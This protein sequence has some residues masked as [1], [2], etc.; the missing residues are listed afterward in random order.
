MAGIGV[1][2]NRMFGR[3]SVFSEVYG[4]V[5]SSATTIAPMILI[6]GSLLLVYQ[7]F[8]F[9]TISYA[10]RALF[11]CSLLYVFV[12]S[13][14]V[15]SIYNTLFSKYLADKTYEEKFGDILPCFYTGLF[16]C[17]ITGAVFAIP[18]YVYEF[19]VGGVDIIYVFT[20]YCLFIALTLTY[21]AMIFMSF[22]KEYKKISLY[23]L[24]GMLLMFFLCWLFISVL[25]I[26]KTFS[27]VLALTLG[28]LLIATLEIL[29]IRRC[30]SENSRNYSGI[31]K[32]M[33][34]HWKLMAANFMYVF[35]LYIHNFVF[36]T[37]NMR[38][39]VVNTYVCCQ[40]YDLATCLAMF[41]NIF[42][43]VVFIVQIENHFA[44]RYKEFNE[45]VIGG[46]L[47]NIEKQ[48]SR[49]FRMLSQELLSLVQFQFV[50]ST[51][52]YFL[53]VVFLPRLGI[54]GLT[55]EIYP[56][57]AAAFFIVFLMYAEVLFL[58]YFD[59]TNGALIT[60]IAFF[61]VTFAVSL[62][63]RD[64]NPIWYGLGLLAGAFTG[65]SVAFARLRW[66][67]RN[68]DRHVFCTGKLIKTV[69]QAMPS[70]MV[71]QASED[72]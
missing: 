38:M 57:L 10:N 32:Y 9:D 46:K 16:L 24:Y 19:I 71:Y 8:G 37:T 12:F 72:A 1:K 11:F 7:I 69:N 28:L 40:P 39:V 63:V 55:M 48:K 23:Y 21:Y 49:L 67:E 31:L 18:F 61:V 27:V 56:C 3:K 26:E 44:G 64:L 60:N 5:Y 51:V 45:S 36:W 52:L 53:A 59:D 70:A 65:W 68:L 33:R 14:I 47:R 13:L 22:T 29:F 30:F 66:V 25:S 43:S 15:T 58:Y 6:I 35:G 62:L 17:I 4:A 50:V 20:T 2:L 34:K 41:T 54:S 42:A